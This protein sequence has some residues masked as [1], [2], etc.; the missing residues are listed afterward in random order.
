MDRSGAWICG[1]LWRLR[2]QTATLAAKTGGNSPKIVT[3]VCREGVALIRRRYGKLVVQRGGERDVLERP[4]P[5]PAGDMGDRGRWE[6]PVFR[7]MPR[8]S[9]R[10]SRSIVSS[11]CHP[12][13]VSHASARRPG[14][15]VRRSI[16]QLGQWLAFNLATFGRRNRFLNQS[17]LDLACTCREKAAL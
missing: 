4:P 17:Q 15:G 11:P 6:W 5:E 9:G 10:P 13:A 7:R 16:D 2:S 3:I 12:N 8:N 1:D 14:T